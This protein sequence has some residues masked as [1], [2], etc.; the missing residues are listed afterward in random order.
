MAYATWN[1]QANYLVGDTVSVAGIDYIAL[2]ASTG[3]SPP[4]DPLTW[5]VLI[6]QGPPGAPGAQGPQGDQG[7]QGDP[8]Q[9]GPTG[10][11]GAQGDPGPPGPPGP[12]GVGG[13]SAIILAG[14]GP[15]VD[16]VGT[17]YSELITPAATGNICVSASTVIVALTNSARETTY[18]LYIDN[19]LVS[20]TVITTANSA[21]HY[22]PIPISGAA[23]CVAGTPIPVE[24]K[25]F[26][27]TPLLTQIIAGATTGFVLC[28]P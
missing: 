16:I 13:P 18:E 7:I 9:I 4:S 2:L 26:T 19:N 21:N 23:P 24:I 22:F 1:P 15:L 10:Q 25:A 5:D 11:T 8:G 12:P 20:N 27:D 17:L 28:S 6:T 3:V 14:G